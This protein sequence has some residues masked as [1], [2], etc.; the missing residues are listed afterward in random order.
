MRKKFTILLS[1]LVL[2]LCNG[3]ESK[4]EEQDKIAYEEIYEVDG[5][6]FYNGNSYFLSKVDECSIYNKEENSVDIR[7]LTGDFDYKHYAF[8]IDDNVCIGEF[9]SD[10][11]TNT[12][13]IY[14]SELT[15]KEY[16]NK[17]LEGY[18]AIY[19]GPYF[20]CYKEKNKYIVFSYP[21]NSNKKRLYD[22]KELNYYLPERSELKYIDEGKIPYGINIYSKEETIDLMSTYLKAIFINYDTMNY[23]KQDE[24][25]KE[26]KK[27]KNNKQKESLV[28]LCLK[29][30][31]NGKYI[32]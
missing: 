28:Y 25:P 12:K 24:I 19:I 15:V 3:C 16:C 14:T 27:I 13:N 32:L 17:Q 7:N 21:L 10:C 5:V 29:H 2:S 1:L 20:T 23:K 6:T 26:N 30:D 11:D 31:G 8:I 18:D 22:G 4:K 9:S